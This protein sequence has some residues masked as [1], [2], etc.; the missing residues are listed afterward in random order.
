MNAVATKERPQVETAANMAL[1]VDR[2][3]LL[4]ALG[5]AS[6]IVERR[7]TIP[8]L[9]NV[10]LDAAGD[11]LKITS[12]D[13]NM[14]VEVAVIANVDAEGATTVSAALLH[15]IVR[16]LPDCPVELKIA[17]DRLHV[18][19]GRSR[20]KLPVIPDDQF[21][22]LKE[23]D[24]ACVFTVPAK[25]LLRAFAS[26]ASAQDTD[27]V[28]RPYCCGVNLEAHGGE[29]TLVAMDGKRIGWATLPVAADVELANA[30]L[31]SKLVST[32][33]KLL[34]GHDSDVR[35]SFDDR[36][37][38]AVVGDAVLASK[39]VDGTFP[40]WRRIIPDGSAA[41]RLLIGADALEAAV[42][43]AALVANERARA[44]KLELTQDKVTISC[45]SPEYGTA[46]EE[47][48]CVWDAGDFVRG[49]NARFLLDTLAASRADELQIE[50]QD[51][52]LGLA[53][54]SNP[55]DASAKWLLAPM[56]V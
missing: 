8:V 45:T 26:V 36:K 7:N 21:P 15:S 27:A 32:L 2:G 12:T 6:A 40:P 41:K 5:H 43:R 37:V 13:L 55:D 39:L 4:R 17:D 34:D 50:F 38:T 53:L 49:F 23:K 46:T 30:I 20:Y 31:S 10:L 1:T 11:V 56:H 35:L 19:A 28:A 24:A 18:V 42:R 9:S 48:P 14:Q 22:R 51:G 25:D 3:D 54:F 47:A 29:L 52:P 44:V 33:N 16:E